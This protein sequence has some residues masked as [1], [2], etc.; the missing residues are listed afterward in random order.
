MASIWWELKRG[1]V[2]QVAADYAVIAWL[3]IKIIDSVNEPLTASV[4]QNL[5]TQ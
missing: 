5:I 3:M 1:K 2:V 4:P